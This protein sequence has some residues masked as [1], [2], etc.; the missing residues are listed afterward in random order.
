M[1]VLI[2][3]GLGIVQVVAFVVACVALFNL[4]NPWVATLVV[5]LVVLVL[6]LGVEG[7]MNDE[8][9]NDAG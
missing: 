8:E 1:D 9:N 6:A 2:R 7:V 4:V 3:V 5:S